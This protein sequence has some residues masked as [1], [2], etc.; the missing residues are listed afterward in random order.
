[1]TEHDDFDSIMSRL[2]QMGAPQAKSQPSAN[3]NDFDSVMSQLEAASQQ[4]EK[5]ILDKMKAAY[6]EAEEFYRK[7]DIATGVGLGAA[8]QKGREYGQEARKKVGSYFLSE[9]A[10]R[11]YSTSVN[12]QRAPYESL[13]QEFPIATAVGELAAGAAVAIPAAM[14]TRGAILGTARIFGLAAPAARLL[15]SSSIPGLLG[16]ASEQYAVGS[17]LGYVE[18]TSEID[19]RL[20]EEERRRTSADVGKLGAGL[21]PVIEGAIWGIKGGYKLAAASSRFFKNLVPE[22]NYLA[23]QTAKNILDDPKSIA[24][25]KASRELDLAIDPGMI[26]TDSSSI[27]T[28]MKDAESTTESKAIMDKVAELKDL[29][30]AQNIQDFYTKVSSTQGD[31]LLSQ[32][33]Q[34]TAKKIDAKLRADVRLSA[35]PAYKKA[36]EAHPTLPPEVEGNLIRNGTVAEERES[37][38]KAYKAQT[39]Y[40]TEV[41]EYVANGG[42]GQ[43]PIPPPS[44]LRLLSRGLEP[45]KQADSESVSGAVVNMAKPGSLEFEH[46]VAQDL[47][48]RGAK[49]LKSVK[50]TGDTLAASQATGKDKQTAALYMHE[51]LGNVS[52][53]Y[54]IATGLYREGM[55]KINPTIKGTIGKISRL[56]TDKLDGLDILLFGPEGNAVEAQKARIAIRATDPIVYDS[57]VRRRLEKLIGTATNTG[58]RQGADPVNFINRLA[59]N[60]ETK[61]TIQRMLA[62]IPGAQEHFNYIVLAWEGA[63]KRASSVKTTPG[64]IK[65]GG[66]AKSLG[67]LT[68]TMAAANRI[69]KANQGPQI[70]T[71]LLDEAWK[72]ELNKLIIYPPKSFKANVKFLKLLND[73]SKSTMSKAVYTQFNLDSAEEDLDSLSDKDL[74]QVTMLGVR[75]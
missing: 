24:R 38:L 30:A 70:A 20:Q 73:I 27:K 10:Q 37:Y 45:W 16:R 5:S 54:K 39:K 11:Q 17:E 57:L 15:A 74:E 66:I 69:F 47:G 40:N 19:P 50:K 46:R 53:D 55:K 33:A 59:K 48:D 9:E 18:S 42:K 75:N 51:I 35:A 65:S 12:K 4:Q 21:S 31:D 72:P 6:N 36:F 71:M 49:E 8:V 63:A 3:D 44:E 61:E 68:R 43:K 67:L 29:K 56:G 23:V 64:I 58:A 34:N 52:E 62:P 1:M 28:L 25:Y 7:A 2:E 22:E 32:S 60:K 13:K 26:A 14:A 41:Q